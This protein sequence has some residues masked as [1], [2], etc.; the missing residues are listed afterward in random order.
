MFST[1]IT[2]R[3]TGRRSH[4]SSL[5][6]I[7]HS[8]GGLGASCAVVS[9]GSWYISLQ[10]K[11][12]QS[13]YRRTYIRTCERAGEPGLHTRKC[14]RLHTRSRTQQRAAN[15]RRSSSAGSGRTDGL[16]TARRHNARLVVAF[17]RKLSSNSI[18][19]AELRVAQGIYILFA[20]ARARHSRKRESGGRREAAAE[21]CIS[22][23]LCSDRPKNE[24]K[25]GT[26]GESNRR[27]VSGIARAC[28]IVVLPTRRIFQAAG[29]TL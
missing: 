4:L 13:I 3:G 29:R 14:T 20:R 8:R 10:V 7:N 12:N 15:Y 26:K 19:A 22:I 23:D 16:Q 18:F 1:H 5:R 17:I 2:H 9:R 28:E 11:C 21:Y 6:H 25:S 27:T 24:E